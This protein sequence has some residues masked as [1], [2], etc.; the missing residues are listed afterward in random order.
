MLDT[1]AKFWKSL[2][3]EYVTK[4]PLSPEAFLEEYG[5]YIPTVPGTSA[6][7]SGELLKRQIEKTR[8]ATATGTDQWAM[9]EL[10]D[11]PV[12]ILDLY[13]TVLLMTGDE[14]DREWP[15]GLTHATVPLLE[16][17]A[18]VRAE[19]NRQ[20]TIFSCWYRT[21]S[22]SI[23]T[24]LKCW[25]QEWMPLGMLGGKK[26]ISTAN[27]AYPLQTMLDSAQ[28]NGRSGGGVSMD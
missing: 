16:K 24:Q 1:L 13:A 23:F 17:G 3:N 22:S 6:T 26:G 20:L 15:E 7:L 10:K 12:E 5:A 21:S 14:D 2:F 27:V 8:T 4:D 25:Q 9:S 28:H 11:L 18:G 19:D